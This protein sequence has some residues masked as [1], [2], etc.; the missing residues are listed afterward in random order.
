MARLGIRIVI[1]AVIVVG[2]LIFRD[3]LSGSAGE[4]RIGDCFDVTNADTV[5]D[6][7]HHPC[8]EGHTAEVV[9]V[10]DYPAA[11]GAAYPSDAE[12]QTY[13]ETACA[14][15]LAAYVGPKVSLDSLDWGLF[16]PA[17][18][19]WSKGERKVTCYGTS[20]NHTTLTKSMRAVTQ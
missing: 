8:T 3:R 4:L 17:E 20:L 18:D 16:Y 13:V 9:L 15:A 7:Q 6:V 5:E 1:I 2:G 10:T 14:N 19:D 11:K 12:L